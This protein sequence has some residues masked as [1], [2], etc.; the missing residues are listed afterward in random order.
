MKI[1]QSINISSSSYNTLNVVCYSSL[2]IIHSIKD[3][4]NFT[5]FTS[6]WKMKG[7][8]FSKTNFKSTFR[9]KFLRA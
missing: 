3:C 9:P 5:C 2:A 6:K 7:I 8:F 4:P 1:R